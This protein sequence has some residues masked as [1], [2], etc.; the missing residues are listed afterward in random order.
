MVVMDMILAMLDKA[1][2]HGHEHR[3]PY[4]G[5][6]SVDK[7]CRNHRSYSWVSDNLLFFD[8]KPRMAADEELK[9]Y[10]NE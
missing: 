4:I 6:K 8:I 9:A 5:A 1:I 3:K 10:E 2:E 7:T